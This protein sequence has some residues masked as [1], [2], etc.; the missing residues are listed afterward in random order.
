MPFGKGSKKPKKEEDLESIEVIEP[1]IVEGVEKEH[2]DEKIESLGSPSNDDTGQENIDHPGLHRIEEDLQENLEPEPEN[3]IESQEIESEKV[4]EIDEESQ[5][6]VET[7]QLD[8]SPPI[9]KSKGKK[10][11]I[12]IAPI[13]IAAFNLRYLAF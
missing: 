13:V 7:Q 3:V 8:E 5:N 12:I 6:L 1:E 2:L 10:K 9:Q 4:Q 11:V